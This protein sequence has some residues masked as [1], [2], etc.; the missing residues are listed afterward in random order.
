M[1]VD[2]RAIGVCE[3]QSH[4]AGE[5]ARH[6]LSV[7]EDELLVQ[8]IRCRAG[9]TD[10]IERRGGESLQQCLDRDVFDITQHAPV[11]ALGLEFGRAN[12]YVRITNATGRSIVHADAKATDKFSRPYPPS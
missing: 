5:L 10:E 12:L 11:L 2:P 4:C 9:I 6:Q 7:E 8:Q 3:D 1:L